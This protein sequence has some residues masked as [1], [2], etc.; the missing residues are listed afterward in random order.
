M[1]ADR[2]GAGGGGDAA[3]LQHGR[4]GSLRTHLC[5]KVLHRLQEH[6]RVCDL[7]VVEDHRD[8][9]RPAAPSVLAPVLLVL[10][11][12]N[13]VETGRRDRDREGT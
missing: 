9:V 7:N 8:V 13:E 4:K 5:R 2:A 12:R 3:N 10:E 11:L 6:H 1:Q